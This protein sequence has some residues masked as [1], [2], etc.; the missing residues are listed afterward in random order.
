MTSVDTEE[1]M[2]LQLT[3]GHHHGHIVIYSRYGDYDEPIHEENNVVLLRDICKGCSFEVKGSVNADITIIDRDSLPYFLPVEIKKHPLL[4]ITYILLTCILLTAFI[5]GIMVLMRNHT[6]SGIYYSATLVLSTFAKAILVYILYFMFMQLQIIDETYQRIYDQRVEMLEEEWGD[7]EF[8]LSFHRKRKSWILV[9]LLLIRVIATS[10]CF[11]LFYKFCIKQEITLYISK[12]KKIVKNSTN[13]N[14]LYLFIVIGSILAGPFCALNVLK[15][16]LFTVPMSNVL[17]RRIRKWRYL[18]L[19]YFITI[20]LNV[21]FIV[22]L[23][24]LGSCKKENYG[25][26]YGHDV[27]YC[28]WGKGEMSDIMLYGDGPLD[29]STQKEYQQMYTNLLLSFVCVIVYELLIIFINLFGFICAKYNELKEVYSFIE[30][31]CKFTESD[32]N[33]AWR[34]ESYF[35]DYK[36][37]LTKCIMEYIKHTRYSF[38]VTNIKNGRLLLCVQ[39][40]D[41]GNDEMIKMESYAHER[42]TD[43]KF[44]SYFK[45]HIA[46]YALQLPVITVMGQIQA[47]EIYEYQI[48]QFEERSK[49]KLN[50]DGQDNTPQQIRPLNCMSSKD[51]TQL[52]LRWILD[53]EKQRSYRREIMNVVKQKNID[54]F[55]IKEQQKKMKVAKYL[56]NIIGDYVNFEMMQAI[57]EKLENIE[58][59][60]FNAEK[61]G[62]VICMFP[63][64]TIQEDL[65]ATIDGSWIA[66]N[67]SNN[68][69]IHK[70]KSI[71]FMDRADLIQ[72]HNFLLK[73]YVNKQNDIKEKIVN[74]INEKYQIN[75]NVICVAVDKLYTIEFELLLIK[76]KN[77]EPIIEESV[78]MWNLCEYLAHNA[79]TIY[80]TVTNHH[81]IHDIY[82]E[83]AFQFSENGLDEWYCS[84]C[85]HHNKMIKIFNKTLRPHSEMMQRCIVCGLGK[86]TAI[87]NTLKGKTKQDWNSEIIAN[88][89]LIECKLGEDDTCQYYDS[90][91][92]FMSKYAEKEVK[93]TSFDILSGM[94]H[95][96]VVKY[97]IHPAINDSEKRNILE[98]DDH[99]V[100][101]NTDEKGE[102]YISLKTAVSVEPNIYS[103]DQKEHS[104]EN[105]SILTVTEDDIDQIFNMNSKFFI[106]PG[107]SFYA[108]IMKQIDLFLQDKE[109]QIFGISYCMAIA[110]WKHVKTFHHKEL[111]SIKQCECECTSKKRYKQRRNRRSGKMADFSSIQFVNISDLNP[112]IQQILLL[113]RYYQEELDIIHVNLHHVSKTLVHISVNGDEEHKMTEMV[114]NNNVFEMDDIE[115]IKSRYTTD[116]GLYGFGIDHQHTDLGPVTSETYLKQEI[117]KSNY[118]S[119]SLWQSKFTKASQKYKDIDD[120]DPKYHAKQFS[121]DYKIDRD[122]KIA[123]VHILC[124]CIYTDCTKLCTDYRSTFRRLD[125]DKNIEDAIQRFK[126]YYLFSRFI[127]EAIE[128]WGQPLNENQVVY[129]GLNRELLFERFSHHFHSPISTTPHKESAVNFAGDDG[130]ILFL[131]NG[132]SEIN[133]KYVISKFEPNQPRFLDVTS[134]SDFT[135][136]SE[137][138]FFGHSIIFQIYNIRNMRHPEQIPSNTLKQLNLLQNIIKNKEIKWDKKTEQRANGLSN[139]LKTVRDMNID[140]MKYDNLND[141]VDAL[142]TYV[143]M[144]EHIFDDM[145]LTNFDEWYNDNEFDRDALVM[146]IGEQGDK[147]QS[148]FYSFLLSKKMEQYF[149]I[150]YELFANQKLQRLK[151][152]NDPYYI[153]LLHFFII[154]QTQFISIFDPFNCS[155]PNCLSLQMFKENNQSVLS[156]GKLTDLF[157]NVSDIQFSNILPATMFS[158]C[159]D[160]CKD[161]IKYSI[162]FTQNRFKKLKTIKFKTKAVSNGKSSALLH[163]KIK[164]YQKE[165]DDGSQNVAINYVFEYESNHV[166]YFHIN[167]LCDLLPEKSSN[168]SQ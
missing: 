71:C 140:S 112:H 123:L 90:L 63:S 37:V 62:E 59:A 2:L 108:N 69:F 93:T 42:L 147:T 130:I 156:I 111:Q 114:P 73:Y 68:E 159:D 168:T 151:Q 35:I 49:Q 16:K 145:F 99:K 97:M 125:T 149:D 101:N 39:Y 28:V 84:E 47:D 127:F 91:I 152:L 40:D 104:W 3:N 136:E 164:K 103:M 23:C 31:E 139:K 79:E 74:G 126:E 86:V 38:E 83:I 61:I 33:V 10:I 65:P 94:T 154:S 107:N 82:R 160:F 132:N 22:A 6:Y 21:S 44:S 158:L 13:S 87:E 161:I 92:K 135:H 14:K 15:T 9:Y 102:E 89:A 163:K 50:N 58:L 20:T 56:E 24:I 53:D 81:L 12:R 41:D 165:I 150:I 30:I 120:N 55:T 43:R 77:N 80:D 70:L 88:Y 46:R 34:E 133:E 117:I 26:A 115:D 98:H 131:K 60:N 64:D 1:Q 129:H 54:G 134:F 124:I 118:G 157:Y 57:G 85:C 109:K 143:L 75:A 106:S 121:Q 78:K 155:F 95:Q 144:S 52:I 11:G 113:E 7:R 8:I 122:A 137:W 105:L 67:F 96:D 148:N 167:K 48:T 110:Y 142:K 162:N 5:H 17:I 146:D 51:I 100:S 76:L 138:L 4:I 153:K 141:E 18:S 128:F 25:V 119:K 27:F 36:A 116:I 66:D 19:M 32:R 72:I 166:I 29:L 45:E